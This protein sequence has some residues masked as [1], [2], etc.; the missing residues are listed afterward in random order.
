MREIL[1]VASQ[2]QVVNALK[3]FFTDSGYSFRHLALP[4]QE[5]ALRVEGNA[6]VVLM[7]PLACNRKYISAEFTWKQ[8]LREHLPNALFII[9]G[10]SNFQQDN[11]L[12]LLSLPNDVPAFLNRAEPAGTNWNPVFTGGLDMRVLLARFFEGH[13]DESVTDE[14]NGIL[15]ILKIAGDELKHPDVTYEEVHRELLLAN[16]LPERWNTL[17]NRWINYYPNF[18]C[19]PFFSLFQ[20][21]DLAL[22]HIAPY[23]R[24][25][26]AQEALFCELDCILHLENAKSDLVKIEQLYVK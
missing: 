24:G 13:G 14:L 21:V 22:Q 20:K 1:C 19:L 17:N 5:E 8:Y 16:R 10:F 23:F 18:E 6:V 25:E 2:I 3:Q 4:V 7:S 9:A 26:C 15:R 11:Y 12:D